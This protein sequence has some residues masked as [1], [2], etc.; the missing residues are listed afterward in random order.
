MRYISTLLL[1]LASGYLFGQE[2]PIKAANQKIKK[3][4]TKRFEYSQEVL[5]RFFNTDK[6]D[7]IVKYRPELSV[8]KHAFIR[9]KTH[10]DSIKNI[11]EE[12]IF[13][14]DFMKNKELIDN[15]DLRVNADEKIQKKIDELNSI[16]LGGIKTILKEESLISKDSIN[17]ISQIYYPNRQTLIELN[18]NYDP[19]NSKAKVRYYWTIKLLENLNK[20]QY[21]FIRVDLTT[22]EIEEMILKSDYKE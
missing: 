11:P 6:L 16:D 5:K 12:Y 2:I 18:N 19:F 3:D 4:F 15:F 9:Y 13:S 8:F 17:K 7:T 20:N 1:F 21:E 14:Y 10:S 22:G